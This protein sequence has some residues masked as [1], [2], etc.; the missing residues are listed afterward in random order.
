MPTAE[1]VV[2]AYFAAL[3]ERDTAAAAKCWAP[4]GVDRL[5]GYELQGPDGVRAYFD[6][7]F[8]AVPDWRFEVTG[9]F[10]DGDR[11][12]AQWRAGGTFAGGPLMGIEPTGARIS[13][14]GCDVFRVEDG[15]IV[16]NDAY[17]D[18]MV[19]ARQIGLLPPQDSPQEQRLTKLFNARTRVAR[20]LAFL[21]GPTRIADGVWLLRGDIKSAM[22]VF[23]IEQPDGKHVLFDA[24]TKPMTNGIAAAA[25]QLGGID[26]IVL[27]HAHADHRGAAPSLGVPV[28]CHRDEVEFAGIEDGRTH[29]PGIDELP[30]RVRHLYKHVLFPRWDGGAVEISG[31]LDEGD[32]VAGFEVVHTPGH[33]PGLITLYRRSD[34]LALGSDLVYMEDSI[35]LKPLEDPVVPGTWW[36][37]DD[38]QAVASVRKIAELAPAT[39][40][41]GH[42]DRPVTGDVRGRLERAADLGPGG[43]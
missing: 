9:V 10:P 16:E 29:H 36:N 11:V 19:L 12:A 8:T 4:H 25:A 30:L 2:R 42:G 3:T 31:T 23:F 39:V 40:W 24:A 22:N 7:L 15:L 1:A 33:S 26:R 14:T 38:A 41:L 13:L 28:W 18:S 5:A 32:E 37:W 34:G 35:K 27:G 17:T 6:E 21:D 43:G 20:R